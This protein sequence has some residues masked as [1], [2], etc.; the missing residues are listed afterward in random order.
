MAHCFVERFAKK[1]LKRKRDRGLGC[2]RERRRGRVLAMVRVYLVLVLVLGIILGRHVS[3]DMSDRLF[4]FDRYINQI[5][6]RD[7]TTM[8]GTV[9]RFEVSGMERSVFGRPRCP[10]PQATVEE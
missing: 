10:I 2:I 4:C 7:T 9:H 1:R 3:G 5:Q 8:C 6:F